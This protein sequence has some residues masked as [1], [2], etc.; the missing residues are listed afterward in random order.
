[1]EILKVLSEKGDERG[2]SFIL[3]GGIALS[4]HGLTRQ[5]GDVDLLVRIKSAE[6]WRKILEGLGYRLFHDH[7]AFKQFSPPRI[8]AWPVDLM[9]VDD[10]TFDNLWREGEEYDL[11]KV[12]VLV[13]NVE[14]L[15]AMKVHALKQDV[16][17]RRLKDIDDIIGLLER[18]NIDAEDPV[19]YGLCMKYGTE[20]IYEQL[21]KIWKKRGEAPS[22]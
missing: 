6:E 5:T 1:M 7:P 20:A 16:P 12:R 4:A 11:G 17:S 8:D 2:I 22:S 14:H 21:R 18:G 15:L 3:V 13:P 19:F 9:V 10:E